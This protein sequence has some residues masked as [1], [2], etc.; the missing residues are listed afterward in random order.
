LLCRDFLV[1]DNSKDSNPYFLYSAS[2][3]GSFCG[4]VAYPFL[5]EIYLT[6]SRQFHYWSAL[7][8][9]L[10]LVLGICAYY[11]LKNTKNVTF[12]HG[13][14]PSKLNAEMEKTPWMRRALWAL[15]AFVP[16]SLMLGTTTFVSMEIGSFPLLWGIP[17]TLYLLTFVIVFMPKPILNHRWMLELQP[18]LLIPLILWLVLENEVAQWSTFALAI[19]YFFVAAMVCHGELYKN[20]PQPAKLT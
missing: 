5:V 8:V 16:S 2:N 17:L 15:Y 12:T 20:R 6:L 19:A 13:I 9:A 11:V 7:Y 1:S 14:K 3:F 4:L 10:I 18:Y